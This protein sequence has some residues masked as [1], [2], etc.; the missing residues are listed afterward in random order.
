MIKL[1]TFVVSDNSRGMGWDG[2]GGAKRSSLSTPL[3]IIN[4]RE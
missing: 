1:L 3:N 4:M 2:M